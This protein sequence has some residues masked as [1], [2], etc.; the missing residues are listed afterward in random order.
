MDPRA[1]WEAMESRVEDDPI[2]YLVDPARLHRDYYPRVNSAS[3][4][5]LRINADQ[6]VRRS[7][8]EIAVSSWPSLAVSKAEF[9]DEWPFRDDR[10]TESRGQVS[11]PQDVNSARIAT[12]QDRTIPVLPPPSDATALGCRCPQ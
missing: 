1:E 6:W 12:R 4:E 8:K 7:H 9:G 10:V 5:I 11:R 3:V 2:P